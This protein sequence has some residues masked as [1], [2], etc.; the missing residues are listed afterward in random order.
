MFKS[1]AVLLFEKYALVKCNRPYD[2]LF[3]YQAPLMVFV[4][5]IDYLIW[6]VFMKNIFPVFHWVLIE[7]FLEAVARRCSVKKVFLEMSQNSQEKTS[8]RVSFLIKLKASQV[9]SC[10]FYEISKNIFFHRTPLVAASVFLST[11]T[12]REKSTSHY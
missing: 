4:V 7:L 8:A 3:L 11:A 2:L 10:E 9:F 6:N 5:K 1:V 12:S